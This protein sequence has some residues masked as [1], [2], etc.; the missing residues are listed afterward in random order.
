VLENVST[1]RYFRRP[2][3]SQLDRRDSF[4][5]SLISPVVARLAKVKM[6]RCRTPCLPELPEL[7][8]PLAVAVKSGFQLYL[9]LSSNLISF[10]I[11]HHLTSYL[12]VHRQDGFPGTVQEVGRCH[13]SYSRPTRCRKGRPAPPTTY[14]QVRQR[15]H[16]GHSQPR[17]AMSGKSSCI[18]TKSLPTLTL[19]SR[20]QR[21][22]L[23]S[24]ANLPSSSFIY[25]RHYSIPAHSSL[26]LPSDNSNSF[27]GFG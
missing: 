27:T 21:L 20:K 24:G 16:L 13:C 10:I 3:T 9:F 19:V 26:H 14:R 17:P 2:P 1:Y 11:A 8:K 23:L 4:E 25:G 5:G 22:L 18:P 6:G 15:H 7:T 12:R